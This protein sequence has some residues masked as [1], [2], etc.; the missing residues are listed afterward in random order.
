MGPEAWL[1]RDVMEYQGQPFHV[2]S[3][4]DLIASR[5]AAGRPVDLDDVRQLLVTDEGPEPRPPQAF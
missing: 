2:V 1:R 3:R 4:I 5:R